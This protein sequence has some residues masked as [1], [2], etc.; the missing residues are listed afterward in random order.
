MLQVLNTPRV[1]AYESS[2]E[3]PIVESELLHRTDCYQSIGDTFV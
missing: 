3:Q 1:A 2:W